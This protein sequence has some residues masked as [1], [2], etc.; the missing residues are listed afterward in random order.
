[1]NNDAWSYTSLSKLQ[2]SPSK[3]KWCVPSFR[4]QVLV[5]WAGDLGKSVE[6]VGDVLDLARQL[7]VAS[8]EPLCHLCLRACEREKERKGDRK[9]ER[10]CV[11]VSKRERESG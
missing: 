3:E 7:E 4:I 9:R 2:T 5:L 1:M 6:N 8:P 10:E 11:C